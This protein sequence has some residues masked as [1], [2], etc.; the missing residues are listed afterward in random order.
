MVWYDWDRIDGI[1]GRVPSVPP[2]TIGDFYVIDFSKFEY[3][4]RQTPPPPDFIIT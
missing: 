2:F 1:L 4:L 3:P